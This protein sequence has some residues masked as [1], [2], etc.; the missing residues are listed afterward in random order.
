VEVQTRS[1]GDGV[2]CWNVEP[3]RAYA[4]EIEDRQAQLTSANPDLVVTAGRITCYGCVALEY[5]NGYQCTAELTRTLYAVP[6]EVSPR[7][8]DAVAPLSTIPGFRTRLESGTLPSTGA[9]QH[10]SATTEEPEASRHR[11]R[12]SWFER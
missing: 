6:G 3:M 1:G 9:G 2:L 8:A 11:R 5:G 10:Q 7:A 12:P 4:R